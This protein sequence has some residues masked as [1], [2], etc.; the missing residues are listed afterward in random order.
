MPKEPIYISD[1]SQFIAIIS[2]DPESNIKLFR[3]QC[4]AE[5]DIQASIFRGRYPEDKEEDIY[6]KIRKYNG[7]ELQKKKYYLDDL[8]DMQHYGAPTRLID[9]SYNPLISLYF[10]VAY[11]FAVNGKVFLHKMDKSEFVSF[12]SEKYKILSHLLYSD[13]TQKVLSFDKIFEDDI[14]QILKDIFIED[15]RLFFL[16]TEIC[17][18]R[19]QAQQG[20]F[21]LCLDKK[22]KYFDFIKEDYIEGL[23]QSI[24]SRTNPII[25][26]LL[27][28]LKKDIFNDK[29]LDKIPAEFSHE[30]LNI[31]NS[32]FDGFVQ[33]YFAKNVKSREVEEKDREEL[34]SFRDNA[35]D[36]FTEWKKLIDQA[37]DN[38]DNKLNGDTFDSFIIKAGDKEKILKQLENIGITPMIVYPDLKG[39]IEHINNKYK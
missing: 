33:R 4:N 35:S 7:Q 28:H 36:F 6:N 21:S 18:S 30:C 14:R 3:G 9:W 1:L 23:R 2:N 13:V 25:W 8:I 29:M 34:A 17:N 16:D 38:Q 12:N 10:A 15:K 31:L 37:L 22:R 26:E 39:T 11:D 32:R 24:D 19:I 27:N 5:W 20:C